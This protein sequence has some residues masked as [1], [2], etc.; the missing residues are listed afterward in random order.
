MVAF[1]IEIDLTTAGR[2]GP[3]ENHFAVPFYSF[4]GYYW[5]RIFRC[6]RYVMGF[7]NYFVVDLQATQL[8]SVGA[9]HSK[10]QNVIVILD[11]DHYSE[12]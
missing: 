2:R 4:A 10:T 9:F 12:T 1:A 8:L 7:D 6:V 11:P 3:L 5:I